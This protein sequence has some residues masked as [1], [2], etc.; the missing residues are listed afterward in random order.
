M[1]QTLL[2]ASKVAVQ[3]FTKKKIL[4]KEIL[5]FIIDNY[6]NSGEPTGSRFLVKK[7]DIPYSPA[8]VRNIMSDL[9]SVNNYEE[10]G[11]LVLEALVF[12]KKKSRSKIPRLG[13]SNSDRYQNRG[14][15]VRGKIQCFDH[16]V[17]AQASRSLET[18]TPPN[19]ER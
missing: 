9:E 11:R 6:L 4:T 14:L 16:A 13:H 19:H 15:E 1:L 12:F 3:N 17:A 7:Y 5:S 2:P 18:E 8:T 10:L